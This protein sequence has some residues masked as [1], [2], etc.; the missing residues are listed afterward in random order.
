MSALALTAIITLLSLAA[1][2]TLLV[3]SGSANLLKGAMISLF[4]TVGFGYPTFSFI[5]GLMRKLELAEQDMRLLAEKDHLTGVWN[6]RYFL[7]GMD[8]A[9]SRIKRRGSSLSLLLVDIDHF[10]TIISTYGEQMFEET[11]RV[12]VVRSQTVI[13][14]GDII[15]R[16]GGELFGLI[17]HDCPGEEACYIANRI[18]AVMAE[19]TL[20]TDTSAFTVTL[21]VGVA[22]TNGLGR[23][24]SQLLTAA[25][26]A[27]EEARSAGR[28]TVRVNPDSCD[29]CSRGIGACEMKISNRKA[30]VA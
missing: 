3:I 9:I 24:A 20:I 15:G 23:S 27:L 14:E 7:E 8:K 19:Q 29:N 2:E 13:R 16:V 11:L 6:R 25:E 12:F 30:G 18:R 26:D 17:L 22:S 4:C 10:E 21:S 5:L 1:T 28:N